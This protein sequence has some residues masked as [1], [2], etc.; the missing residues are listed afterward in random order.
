MYPPPVRPLATAAATL[1]AA[2]AVAG[3]GASGG[4]RVVARVGGATIT[5]SALEYWVGVL[6]PANT[7]L[8]VPPLF[9]ACVQR[10]RRL[11]PRPSSPTPLTAACRRSYAELEHA[12]LRRL[13]GDRWLLH[14][15]A[16]LGTPV[17]G[18]QTDRRFKEKYGSSEGRAE[19][20]ALVSIGR[21]TASDVRLEVQAELAA[22][23]IRR[24]VRAYSLA[25]PSARVQSYYRHNIAQ[26]YLPELRD[27]Q[28]VGNFA[29]IGS[30]RQIVAEVRRGVPFSSR[31]FNRWLERADFNLIAREKRIFDRIVFRARQGVLVGPLRDNGYYFLFEV[32]R[33]V[34]ARVMS[35]SE[36]TAAI[37]ARLSGERRTRFIASL[38]SGLTAATSCSP[39]YVV[40]GCE[41]Y[42]GPRTPEDFLAAAPAAG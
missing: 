18:R 8:L 22:Q 28:M 41:R 9:L 35:L 4:Q 24:R 42:R 21:Y 16:E 7:P 10:L 32:T 14:E 2:A 1:A 3:C 37:V 25:I 13:I 29:E 33:I 36:A 11:T 19:Y 20:E 40:Q 17:S 34:P 5:E 23:A 27:V 38:T 39:G 30:A 26:F 12:A 6:T 31:S 15:A